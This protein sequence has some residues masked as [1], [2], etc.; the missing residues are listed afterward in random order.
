MPNIPCDNVIDCACDNSPFA[1]LSSEAPDLPVFISTY[2]GSF[3]PPL[4]TAWRDYSCQRTCESTVSQEAADLCAAERAFECSILSWRQPATG[5]TPLLPVPPARSPARGGFPY[6][7]HI[8]AEQSCAALC[9]D[10]L[11]FM[12]TV[13]AGAFAAYTQAQ[14]DAKAKSYACR[15]A[16][17]RR[18]CLSSLTS[19]ICLG[20]PY[21]ATIHAT[22]RFLATGAQTDLW[23]FES[24][25]LPPGLTF[26]GGALTG[27][28][29]TITGTPTTA[30]SYT[31]FIGVTD[32][33]G[34]FMAK[35][36]TLVVGTVTNA[37]SLPDGNVLSEYSAQLLAPALTDPFFTIIS[38]ALPD[39]L[40]M[41]EAG[42]ITGTPT[43]AQTAAF[44]VQVEDET[45]TCTADCSIRIQGG[46][47]WNVVWGEFSTSQENGTVAGT[48][49]P[50]GFSCQTSCETIPLAI[51]SGASSNNDSPQIYTGP[52]VVANAHVVATGSPDT[53]TA[54]GSS[55]QLVVV[56]DGE[57]ILDTRVSTVG[58]FDFPITIAEGI[59]SQIIVFMNQNSVS[60]PLEYLGSSLNTVCTFS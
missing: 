30:G 28:A 14:A 57:V 40:T 34:D 6:L 47:P 51:G 3:P 4:G 17:L 32:P 15:Q 44:T 16:Q 20:A 41:D 52:E 19:P 46:F 55:M 5:G 45:A 38:G 39:G 10:G 31:F 22:G 13:P 29:A 25:T 58:E 56:Q 42:A 54:S 49:N 1:N 12:F 36:Y 35:G 53:G 43:T 37:G 2:Y 48:F 8:S 59:D 50:T 24:G 27:G 60:N 26:H 23:A 11:P 33:Q 21:S 9:G 7:P 18:I